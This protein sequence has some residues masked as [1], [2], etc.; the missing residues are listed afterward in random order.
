VATLTSLK[1]QRPEGLNAVLIGF[2]VGFLIPPAL[3]WILVQFD[4]IVFVSFVLYL[5]AGLLIGYL[6]IRSSERK[7]FSQTRL[8]RI[9][10]NTRAGK[11]RITNEDAILIMRSG[12]L[13]FMGNYD[14]VLLIVADGVGGNQ[15]GN[16][17][18]HNCVT[19]VAKSVFG[20]FLAEE[21]QGHSSPRRDIL[22]EA[23]AN[24]SNL[25]YL[26]STQD[27]NLR[28]MATTIVAAIMEKNLL[29]LANVGNSRAYLLRDD[30]LE[31]LTKDH[32]AVQELVEA[33][34]ITLE[35]ARVHPRRNVITRAVGISEETSVETYLCHLGED[36]ILLLC[37]DG[38]TDYVDEDTIAKTITALKTDPQGACIKLT[39]LALSHGSLDDISVIIAPAFTVFQ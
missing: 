7:A 23:I 25:I 11:G 4:T 33:G 16:L 12:R 5:S 9:G 13:S 8:D 15:A 2:I 10:Y 35:Q 29:S 1:G 3:I 27:A 21:S 34:E 26:Q 31:Q 17:A 32:T 18:S 28:G 20:A 22:E 24:V 36:D 6:L 14:Q 38:L 30:R 39:E 37:T 19:L